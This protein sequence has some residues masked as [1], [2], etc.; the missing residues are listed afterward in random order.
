MTKLESALTLDPRSPGK[1]ALTEVGHPEG[2]R[3]W[4]LRPRFWRSLRVH[5][6]AVAGP[7]TRA[8]L[9]TGAQHGEQDQG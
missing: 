5:R 2:S 6:R 7:P 3:L 9:E 4:H 8:L 1:I